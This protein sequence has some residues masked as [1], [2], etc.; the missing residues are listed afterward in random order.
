MHD[1][2][3]TPLKRPTARPSALQIVLRTLSRI[4]LAGFYRER[5][6]IGAGAF[7]GTGPVIVAANHSNSLA[8]GV[9]LMGMLPR[10]PQ[11][12][13]ASSVWAYKPVVPFLNAARVIPIY[14]RHE[15][16]DAAG[17]NDETFAAA[18]E[19]LSKGSVLAIFPEG[20]SHNDPTLRTI[21]T[22]TARIAIQAQASH[23]PM[24]LSIQPIGLIFEAKSRFRSRML[25]RYGAPFEITAPA[26]DVEA[27][28]KALTARIEKALAAVTVSTATGDG[29]RLEE[30]AADIA[31]LPAPALPLKP[32]FPRIVDARQTL[33]PVFEKKDGVAGLAREVTDYDA[34]LSAAG[35]RDR[36]VAASYPPAAL[37][38][39]V[40]GS[41]GVLCL[42]LP[43]AIPGALLNLLPY[44]IAK[45]LSR[46][47]DLDKR[48][49]WSL[50][51]SVLLFPLFWLVEAFVLVALWPTSVPL[52]GTAIVLGCLLLAPITGY[53]ALLFF[54]RLYEAGFVL[55]GWRWVR[56]NP[57]RAD[58]LRGA[59]NRI[60]GMIAQIGAD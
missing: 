28:A 9:V 36:Q 41:A 44:R 13:A 7:P 4:A 56:K 14:R 59:R 54:D 43:A 1:G 52:S 25:V 27:N 31:S 24:A 38:R 18:G 33:R 21:K 20:I 47:R 15:V 37:G 39:Y 49:T 22:G 5:S 51:S 50:F 42:L 48:A 30:R 23:G 3:Q 34:A 10:I 29:A 40:L 19:A 12:L 53:L 11:F 8:D 16:S 45:H 17:R 35:L 6:E 2:N 57:S 58:E 46:P 60:L 55:R 26:G 32:P